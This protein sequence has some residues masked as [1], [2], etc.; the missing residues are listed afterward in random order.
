MESHPLLSFNFLFF[1]NS[2]N[3]PIYQYYERKQT[4]IAKPI[5]HKYDIH[6]AINNKRVSDE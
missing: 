2:L 1:L 4:K 6:S 3:L 5:Y